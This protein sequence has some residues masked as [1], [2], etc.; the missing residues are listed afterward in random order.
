MNEAINY[1]IDDKDELNPNMDSNMYKTAVSLSPTNEEL[2]TNLKWPYD[3]TKVD[4]PIMIA[5]GMEHGDMLYNADGY[6]TAW[7]MWQLQ[8]DEEAS[9]AFDGNNPEILENKIY[10]DQKIDLE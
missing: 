7:F 5:T 4:I 1:L 3:A 10:Q 8:G 6:V 2:A 9:K